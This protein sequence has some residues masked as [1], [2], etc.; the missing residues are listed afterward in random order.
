MRFYLRVDVEEVGYDSDAEV[1]HSVVSIKEL[2]EENE[3]ELADLGYITPK[4][5]ELQEKLNR[6]TPT[7]V[8]MCVPTA[9]TRPAESNLY[10][11]SYGD[12]TL[13]LKVDPLT[14]LE[15]NILKEYKRHIAS[16]ERAAKAVESKK[17]ANAKKREERKLAAAK[18]LLESKGIKVDA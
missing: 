3:S 15:G 13:C 17:K 14:V 8:L 7:N 16:K 6:A 1:T 9:Y 18:K 12:Y 2:L 4:A 11:I 10:D 5:R